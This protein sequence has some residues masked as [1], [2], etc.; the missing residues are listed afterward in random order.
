MTKPLARLGVRID[1]HTWEILKQVETFDVVK[2]FGFL[3]EGGG[4]VV[5][6]VYVGENHEAFGDPLHELTT[7]RGGL[8]MKWAGEQL[9]W[10]E[11]SSAYYRAA[12]RLARAERAL[13]APTDL[14]RE[15]HAAAGEEYAAATRER[16]ET[17]AA[18]EAAVTADARKQVEYE[19]WE[20]RNRE[21]Q[22]K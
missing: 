3:I 2:S 21:E 18:F 14:P 9:D 13:K 12:V 20:R 4:P 6:L 10:S 11:M 8:P 5:W 22:S 1:E 7:K 16:D 15:E 17:K 19:E